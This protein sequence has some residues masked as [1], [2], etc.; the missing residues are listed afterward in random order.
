MSSIHNG[1]NENQLGGWRDVRKW[2][3]FMGVWIRKPTAESSRN[4]KGV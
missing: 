1:L 4:V 3:Q 2:L